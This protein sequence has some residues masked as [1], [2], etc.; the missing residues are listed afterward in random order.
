M[1]QPAPAVAAATSPYSYA[2]LADLAVA[3]PMAIHARIRKAAALKPEQAPGLAAGHVRFFIEA[4]V[5]SLI[6]GSGPLAARISYLVDLPLAANGKAPKLKSKQPVLIFARP[7]ASG[8]TTD[9]GS[10]RLVAPDA[11]LAWDPATEARLRAILTELV[12]PGA[13]PAITG[14]ANG[15]HVPGTLPGEGETQLFLNTATG[16]PVSLTV[17]TAADGSRRWAAAFGEIVD[18]SAA[19]PR[20]DTL[21]WYRLACGLPKALPLDKLA[22][23]APEDRKKA[24]ADYA[25]ILGALGECTRTRAPVGG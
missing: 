25:M 4:D 12:K 2:D 19:V 16:D 18:G 24:A 17:I 11:Q 21:A 20:R 13:P 9:T 22:G 7:V 1:E 14:I 6:R 23:T 15:F 5:V 3:A 8:T 10:V